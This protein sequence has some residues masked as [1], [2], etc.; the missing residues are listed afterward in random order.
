MNRDYDV[1]SLPFRLGPN[2]IAPGGYFWNTFKTT[3]TSDDSRRV[4]GSGGLDVGGYYGGDKRTFRA[5]IN[6]L[7]RETLLI[8][9]Q[10]TRNEIGLPGAP[11][12]VT[13]TL[14]TRASYSLSPTLF[15]KAFMQY[16]DE[17]RLATLNLLLWSIY[18]PGSDLYVVYNQGWDTNAP[19]PEMLRPRN[20]MLA[21]KLTYW[22]SR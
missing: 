7:P 12:Y 16:N 17:R 3:L 4:Y 19:G 10:Y 21:I 9:N 2:V 5:S 6:F 11:T 8:E 1:L 15:V 20:R 13:N 14:S 22:L 18:R